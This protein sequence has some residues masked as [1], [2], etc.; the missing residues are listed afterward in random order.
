MTIS[1]LHR[2]ISAGLSSFHSQAYQYRPYSRS[3]W[4]ARMLYF[5]DWKMGLRLG[6]RRFRFCAIDASDRV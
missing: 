5:S 4:R 6:A 3:S 2:K 1:A